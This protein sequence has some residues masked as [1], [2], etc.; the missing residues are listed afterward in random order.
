MDTNVCNLKPV[1]YLN[2]LN[3][4]YV[5]IYMFIKNSLK[6][7]SINLK[8]LK[9]S[10]KN[11][12]TGGNYDKRLIIAQF[13]NLKSLVEKEFNFIDIYKKFKI[14]L[15]NKRIFS[16]STKLSIKD[17]EKDLIHLDQT[18]HQIF[19]YASHSTKIVNTQVL[20]YFLS[21]PQATKQSRGSWKINHG[22]CCVWIISA[23]AQPPPR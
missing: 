3:N 1:I 4:L 2:F 14:H 12:K 9:L 18:N 17:I 16:E 10:S 11:L 23:C 22:E 19:Y 6:K 21:R 7:S 5:Y 20:A 8:N 13:S 15:H